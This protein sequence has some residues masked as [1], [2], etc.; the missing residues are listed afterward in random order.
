MKTRCAG[1]RIRNAA[2]LVEDFPP[3]QTR[4]RSLPVVRLAAIRREHVSTGISKM[5][6]SIEYNRREKLWPAA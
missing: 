1:D 4:A 2:V 5:I 3:G 6:L